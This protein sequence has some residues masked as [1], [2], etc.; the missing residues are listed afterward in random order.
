LVYTNHF[1]NGFYT[2]KAIYIFILCIILNVWR[3]K[4][5]HNSANAEEILSLNSEHSQN[6]FPIFSK[7]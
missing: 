6:F 7:T 4:Q 5:F 1:R 2:E 3:S